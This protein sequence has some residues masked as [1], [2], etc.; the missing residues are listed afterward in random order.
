MTVVASWLTA[1]IA[2][3]TAD[4]SVASASS[5]SS[6]FSPR[7]SLREKSTGTVTANCTRFSASQVW[8][9]AALRASQVRSK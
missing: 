4:G 8:I 3:P 1:A 6:G 2:K 9:S 7:R 5:N